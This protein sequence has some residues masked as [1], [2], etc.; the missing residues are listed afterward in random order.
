MNINSK[1]CNS[2]TDTLATFTETN[3]GFLIKASRT[4][5]ISKLFKL[6]IPIFSKAQ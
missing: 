6:D 5:E 4:D 1:Y 2:V 3:Y